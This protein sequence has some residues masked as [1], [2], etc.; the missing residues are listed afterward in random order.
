MNLADFLRT[1][2]VFLATMFAWVAVFWEADSTP[3]PRGTHPAP[4]VVA[5]LLGGTVLRV[6]HGQNRR[7]AALELAL[8]KTKE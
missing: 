6:F 4:Y 7:I 5:G 2:P 3:N 8:K 1:L